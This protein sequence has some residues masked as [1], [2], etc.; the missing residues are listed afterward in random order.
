MDEE[1]WNSVDQRLE[2]QRNYI[3]TDEE[4]WRI[5]DEEVEAYKVNLPVIQRIMNDHKAQLERRGFTTELQCDEK[6]I[7]FRYNKNGYYGP[8]GFRSDQH[9]DGPL[10]MSELNPA[11]NPNSFIRD[12]DID[13]NTEV[14]TGFDSDAFKHFVRNN[15]DMFLNPNNLITTEVRREQLRLASRAE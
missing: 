11:G 4:R 10:V 1:Y 12:N 15:L 7:L 2:L 8:G 5:L 13:K 9:I 3:L 14:G 6:A